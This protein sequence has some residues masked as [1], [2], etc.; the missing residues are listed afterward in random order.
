[1][2]GSSGE[3]KA[4]EE[5]EKEVGGGEKEEDGGEWEGDSWIGGV[6]GRVEWVVVRRMVGMKEVEGMLL[7]AKLGVGREPDPNFFILLFED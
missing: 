4:G 2:G 7:N 5:G 6:E 3:V 1:M